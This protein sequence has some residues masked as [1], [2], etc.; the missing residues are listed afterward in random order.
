MALLV[1]ETSRLTDNALQ[2]FLVQEVCGNGGDGSSHWRSQFEPAF[3]LTV[4]QSSLLMSGQDA[5]ASAD[6]A[7]VTAFKRLRNLLLA[8][9][10]LAPAMQYVHGLMSTDRFSQSLDLLG[11]VSDVM[12]EVLPHSTLHVTTAMLRAV[13]AA[14]AARPQEEVFALLAAAARVT[15]ATYGDGCSTLAIL[16][17]GRLGRG[18]AAASLLS[19]GLKRLSGIN[20][21]PGPTLT[22]HVDGK[23]S[24]SEVAR[25]AAQN[26]GYQGRVDVPAVAHTAGLDLDGMD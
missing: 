7:A 13:C 23:S 2:Q 11:E 8:S 1:Q 9:H 17:E 18:D 15:D 26:G 4:R 10:W 24:V 19:R 6:R 3:G 12:E 5:G 14:D 16:M 22:S 21:A 20:A 25:D